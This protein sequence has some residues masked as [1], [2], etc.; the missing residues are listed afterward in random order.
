MR[1]TRT[2]VKIWGS[3]IAL[4]ALLVGLSGTAHAEEDLWEKAKAGEAEVT[5]DFEF[6]R[7]GST[8]VGHGEINWSNKLVTATG[9]AAANL[10]APSVAVARLQA[11]RAAK[12]DALRNIMETIQGVRVQG[13]ASAG[14]LM[15]NGTIKSKIEGMARGFKIKDTRYY[16]DG[17]VDVVVTM[18]LDED[19]TAV[20]LSGTKKSKKARK[21]VPTKG[22]ATYS[23]LVVNARGLGALASISPRILDEKGREVYG[24]GVVSG[25][26]MKQGGI[27]SYVK[28]PAKAKSH[29]RAGKTP[30]VVKAL[31]VSSKN[32]TDIVISNA[33]ADK[34]R[35]KGSNLTFLKDAHVV[36]VVD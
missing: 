10:N 12:L 32:K 21:S 29:E 2:N 1:K 9:S 7:E 8:K 20:L 22:P 33:D 28:A 18:P 24:A 17:S 14:D 15:S 6:P 16:S 13:S 25:K 5:D 4:S 30:L 36:I 35:D 23:G 11:E 27:A 31:K 26:G 34:L 19:F 3:A